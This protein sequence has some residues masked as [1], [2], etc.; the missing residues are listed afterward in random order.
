MNLVCTV[1]LHIDYLEEDDPWSGILSATHFAVRS[2][3]HTT[4]QSTPGQLVSVHYMLLNTPF[5]T[6]W[7]DIRLHKK[8]IIDR[9]NQLENKN[10]KPHIY[11]M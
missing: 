3:Y 5:I 2:T 9:N 11:I 6:D 8:I 1:D 7:E 10:R 4:L